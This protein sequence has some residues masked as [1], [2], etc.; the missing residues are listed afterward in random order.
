MK[1]YARL[2][3]NKIYEYSYSFVYDILCFEKHN[4]FQLLSVARKLF[5]SVSKCFDQK[6]PRSGFGVDVVSIEKCTLD[7]TLGIEFI[8]FFQYFPYGKRKTFFYTVNVVI[9]SIQYTCVCII[10]YI[11]HIYIPI[12]YITRVNSSDCK[13]EQYCKKVI[14]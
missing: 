1:H 6:E 7:D 5:F 12:L 2:P 13:L 3:K 9:D 14:L 11:V 4:I 8:N 10:Q